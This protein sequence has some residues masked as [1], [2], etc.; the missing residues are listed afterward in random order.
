MTQQWRVRV[1][2]RPKRRPNTELLVVAVLELAKQLQHAA[3]ERAEADFG[4]EQR[5]TREET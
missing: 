2:G 4:D 1:H 5:P 3:D